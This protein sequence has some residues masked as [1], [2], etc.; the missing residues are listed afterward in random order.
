MGARR[1][2]REALDSYSLV[3]I[4]L[5]PRHADRLSGFVVGIGDEGALGALTM[6]GARGPD[7]GG[8]YSVFGI[9]RPGNRVAYCLR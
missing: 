7:P 4:R 5:T 6:D 1:R 8:L 3:R 2:L 9:S